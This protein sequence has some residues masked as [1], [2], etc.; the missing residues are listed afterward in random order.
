VRVN[1]ALAV[2]DQG[3]SIASELVNEEDSQSYIGFKCLD[4]DRH[5]V[6]VSQET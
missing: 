3:P 4:P 2:P 6:E 5:V 1:L